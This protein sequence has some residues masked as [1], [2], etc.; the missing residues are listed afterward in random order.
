MR[1]SK[2]MVIFLVAMLAVAGW[3]YYGQVQLVKLYENSLFT[4]LSHS[5]ANTHVSLQS[6]SQE[7]DPT[8]RMK[9][10]VDASRNALPA[11]HILRD[12][13]RV[14]PNDSTDVLMYWL[15]GKDSETWTEPYPVTD[16]YVT[17]YKQRI[18]QLRLALM[19]GTSRVSLRELKVRV[20]QLAN[21][22][23]LRE[24]YAR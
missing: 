8:A 12:D 24:S 11:N 13:F 14:L 23:G 7:T 19:D 2:A 16:E 10:L 20:S 15:L 22:L 4:V 9:L 6:A 5:L 1:R 17:A 18:E 3:R 21:Q